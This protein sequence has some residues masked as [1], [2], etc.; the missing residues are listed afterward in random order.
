MEGQAICGESLRQDLE[1]PTR[2]PFLRAYNDKVIGEPNELGPS[3]Q[4]W[5]DFAHEPPVQHLVEIDVCQE[6]RDHSA[7]W[8]SEFGK[9]L[10]PIL[11]D[12]SLQPFINRSS[13]HTVY[14]PL[15]EKSTKM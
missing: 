8:R 14:D 12:P 3:S 15:V 2:I 1:H 13:Q 9:G 6:R 4:T 5:L 7:L 11:G 10:P